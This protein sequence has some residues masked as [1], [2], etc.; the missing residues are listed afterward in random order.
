MHLPF[1]PLPPP[2]LTVSSYSDFFP[3]FLLLGKLSCLVKLGEGLKSRTEQFQ[4]LRSEI[5][6]VKS[7]VLH[8]RKPRNKKITTAL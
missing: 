4:Q 1:P 3:F 8:I 6:K 7:D 5:Q 2:H